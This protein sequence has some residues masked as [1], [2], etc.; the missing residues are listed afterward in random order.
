MLSD[1][2]K[3]ILLRY[4]FFIVVILSQNDLIILMKLSREPLLKGKIQYG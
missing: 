4:I 3:S 2:I 1:R